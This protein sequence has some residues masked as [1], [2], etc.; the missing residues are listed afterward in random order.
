MREGLVILA[1]ILILLI[2][3]AIRYR[4]QLM[5]V[6]HVWRMLKSARSAATTREKEIDEPTD[7][8]LVNCAKCGAWVSQAETVKI[9]PNTF[10]CV[11][12]CMAASVPRS[13]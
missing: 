10:L 13:R 4:K 6:V 7:V 12:K 11:E 3:T 1:I 8:P 5:T 2:L 9:S